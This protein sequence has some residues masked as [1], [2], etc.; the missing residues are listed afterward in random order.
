MI[1]D[2][3]TCILLDLVLH[4]KFNRLGL[5]RT[6]CKIKICNFELHH[7]IVSI[8]FIVPN[9]NQVTLLFYDQQVVYVYIY[10]GQKRSIVSC[11][12]KCHLFLSTFFL[13]HRTNIYKIHF[14]FK[15]FLFQQSEHLV[16]ILSGMHCSNL[17][18]LELMPSS[19]VYS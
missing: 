7:Y 8:Q 9:M 11:G 14:T 13:G 12:K 3:Y 6:S 4:V 2:L 18:K 5:L 16:I 10:Q 1:I 17:N 15:S 19:T